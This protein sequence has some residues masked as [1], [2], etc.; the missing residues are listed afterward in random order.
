MTEQSEG[1]VE[2]VIRRVAADVFD[3]PFA[4]VSATS[5]PYSI[6]G[7]DSVGHLTLVLALEE[8]LGGEVLPDEMERMR[9]IA[10]VVE[11]LTGK[12]QGNSCA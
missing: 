10:D 1:S 11:I 5:S 12:L 4:D 6:S 7:W 2:E 9:T 3:V 8:E